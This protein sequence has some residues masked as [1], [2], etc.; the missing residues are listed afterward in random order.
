MENAKKGFGHNFNL[1]CPD[2]DCH[3]REGTQKNEI[4]RSSRRWTQ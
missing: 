2:F 1:K 4:C 3:D